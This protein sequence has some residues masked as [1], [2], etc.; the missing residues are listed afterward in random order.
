MKFLDRLGDGW[1]IVKMIFHGNR[2][3]MK[4]NLIELYGKLQA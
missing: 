4:L 3:L 2:N 1:V